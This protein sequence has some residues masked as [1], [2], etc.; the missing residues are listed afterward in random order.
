M[1]ERLDIQKCEVRA[2]LWRRRFGVDRA[3]FA[4]FYEH[5]SQVTIHHSR[6]VI[7]ETAASWVAR[8]DPNEI[9]EAKRLTVNSLQAL[10]ARTSKVRR[11]SE[12]AVFRAW[13]EPKAPLC[14]PGGSVMTKS[15]REFLVSICYADRAQFYR[16]CPAMVWSILGVRREYRIRS[17]GLPSQTPLTS[18]IPCSGSYCDALVT[19]RYAYSTA[20][21]ARKALASLPLATLHKKLAPSVLA[22]IRQSVSPKG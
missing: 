18:S 7:G 1:M 19:E 8:A 11:Q 14:D 4:V 5:L 12:E 13:A 22:T 15:E 3:P 2:F 20:A 9:A 10:Q 17:V 21:H 6:P 16:E